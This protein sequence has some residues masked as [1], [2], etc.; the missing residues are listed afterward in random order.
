MLKKYSQII[1]ELIAD[2][3]CEVEVQILLRDQRYQELNKAING[4]IDR[5]EQLLPE[6]T[7]SMLLFDLDDLMVQREALA[8]RMLYRQGLRDGMAV[9]RLVR[10]IGKS[11]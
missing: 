6:G 8:F 7:D 10:L 4:V 2:R 1:R 3:A 5:I 9:N 11:G